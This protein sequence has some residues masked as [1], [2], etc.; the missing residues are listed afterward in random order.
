YDLPV[1][2]INKPRSSAIDD[3]VSED[4]ESEAESE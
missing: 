2:A 3:D 4:G 1:V